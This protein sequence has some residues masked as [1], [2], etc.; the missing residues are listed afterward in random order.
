[1]KKKAIAAMTAC[2]AMGMAQAQIESAREGSSYG[3]A[4][5]GLM[6]VDS[7]CAP[8]CDYRGKMGKLYAGTQVAPSLF[9]E[10]ALMNFGKSKF[11]TTN[12][13]KS[14]AAALSLAY[15]KTFYKK[16]ITLTGRAGLAYQ[17]NTVLNPEVVT[18]VTDADGFETVTA[19]TPASISTSSKLQPL[20]GIGAEIAITQKIHAVASADFSRVKIEQKS[21]PIHAYGLGLSLN[22]DSK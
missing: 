2:L 16:F 21:V 4:V 9:V 1:M 12:L 15:R 7:A 5:A 6:E 10:I 19:I 22:F 14:Q 3:G 8:G 13:A 17:K 20:L 18:K 11:N